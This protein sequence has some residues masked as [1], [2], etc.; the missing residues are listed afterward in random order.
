MDDVSKPTAT[1]QAMLHS[2]PFA[3]LVIGL[4]KAQRNG[5]PKVLNACG[6]IITRP[7]AGIT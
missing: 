4:D 7:E 1:H 2:V 3:P 6:A 5:Q